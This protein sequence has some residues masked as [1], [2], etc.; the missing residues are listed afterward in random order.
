MKIGTIILLIGIVFCVATY[1]KESTIMAKGLWAGVV[2]L[3]GYGYV[4]LIALM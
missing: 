4:K 2:G 1:P 3:A